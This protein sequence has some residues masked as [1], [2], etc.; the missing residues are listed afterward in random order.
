MFSFQSQTAKSTSQKHHGHLSSGVGPPWSS[1]P[2]TWEWPG[3]KCSGDHRPFHQ[4]FSGICNKDPNSTNYG[5]DP[6]GQ[7]YCP[8]W[9]T[10]KDSY[11]SGVK[12][13]ESVGGWPL[14]VD[15]GTEDMDQ[16]ISSADQWS[17]WKVQL[18]FDQYAWDFTQ[19]KEVRVEEPHW[20]IGSWHI[21]APKTQPKGSAPTTSCLEDNLAFQ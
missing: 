21:I 10:Q 8:L 16:S 15:G 2:G 11:Q 17:M 19:G 5:K 6:M 12:F 14:W 4:V 18:H 20:N 7:I 9:S 3:R 1:M 13:W